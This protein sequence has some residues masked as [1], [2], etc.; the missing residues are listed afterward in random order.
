LALPALAMGLD[1]LLPR[2][3]PRRPPPPHVATVRRGMELALGVLVLVAA[4]IILV[5]ASLGAPLEDRMEREF[6]V[7]GID[8]LV[9]DDP[10]ARVVAEYGWGGYVIHRVFPTG[11]RV[12]VDGR[13][14]M[15][16]QAILE[17]YGEVRAAGPGWTSIVDRYEVDALVFP[18]EATISRGP[19]EAAGW[20]EAYRDA[21]EVLYLRSCPDS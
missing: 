12:M 3:A 8:R 16:D 7:Q 18:P 13:N 1:D 10:D 4:W 11:G 6:P 2:R 19:A 21:N 17:E 14:D 20:C 9:R 5:P 15:Y